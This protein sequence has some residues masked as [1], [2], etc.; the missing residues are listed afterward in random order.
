MAQETLL[1]LLGPFLLLLLL[2]DVMLVVVV[3]LLGIAVVVATVVRRPSCRV[4]HMPLRVKS[5]LLT[6]F[7]SPSEWR[8]S[9]PSSCHGGWW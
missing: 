1:R 5:V 9:H 3:L 2:L 6:N 7:G 4:C 8:S